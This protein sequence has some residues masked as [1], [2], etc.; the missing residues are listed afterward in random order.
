M[1]SAGSGKSTSDSKPWEGQQPYLRDIYRMAQRDVA[2]DDLQYYPGST[3][4]GRDP[5]TRQGEQMAY[6]R[7]MS[8]NT[9]AGYSAQNAADTLQGKYLDPD[10]NP[11]LAKTFGRA[12]GDVTR[13]FNR[14]VLPG[15]ESRFASSGRLGSGAHRGAVG[16]TG[17][18]LAGELGRL[19]E[20]IYGGNYQ[21]E[22]GRQMATQQMA[23]QLAGMDYYGAQALQGLGGQRQQHQQSLLDD[24]VAKFEFGRD[25]P[26]NRIARYS[27]LIGQPVSQSQSRASNQNWSAIWCHAAAEY[28]GWWTPSWI[29]CAKWINFDWPELSQEGA[30]FFGWYRE[31]SVALA[32]EIRDDDSVRARWK[33][34]FDWALAR[35]QGVE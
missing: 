17:R 5:W 32:Q 28:F 24:L 23:P 3:V 4:A 12:A 18:M 6:D 16:E 27:N 21:Q 8:G 20:S 9:V 13:N 25:E 14:A 34:F 33:P 19:G 31:H 10:S 29:A 26:Y 11:W 30:D 7:A 2:G 35:G 15:M 22:R 1:A